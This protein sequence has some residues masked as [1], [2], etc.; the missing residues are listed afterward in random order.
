MQHDDPSPSRQNSQEFSPSFEVQRL[1]HFPGLFTDD[2]L[3]LLRR[4]GARASALCAQTIE[5]STFKEHSFVQVMRREAPPT[6]AFHRLWLS[7]IQAVSAEA[8]Y[9]NAASLTEALEVARLQASLAKDARTAAV[10]LALRSAAAKA[11]EATEQLKLEVARLKREVSMVPEEDWVRY[12]EADRIAREAKMR[13]DVA[14]MQRKRDE[15]A[16]D[17]TCATCGRLVV[18]CPCGQDPYPWK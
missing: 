16:P 14:D 6:Q 10:T 8:A 2:E 9:A 5:P 18:S 13:Q 15:G 7:Y 3:A 4:F 17:A 12:R 11:N 1:P